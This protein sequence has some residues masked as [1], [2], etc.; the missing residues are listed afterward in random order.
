MRKNMILFPVI[1]SLFDGGAAA[2]GT[3]GG[4]APAAGAGTAGDTQGTAPGDAGRGKAGE[5]LE[6]KILYGKQPQGAKSDEVRQTDAGT[7]KDGG[8]DLSAE[9]REAINGKYKD[10][11]TA[12]M[13]RIIDR[14]FKEAKTTEAALNATKPLTDLLMQRYGIADGDMG[15]LMTAVE[16]DDP[17]L[18]R[19][20]EEN[21]MSVEQQRQM[22][23]YE[24]ENRQLRAAEA[25]RVNEDR[26][27]ET[28][29][30]WMREAEDLGKDYPGF[31][32]RAEIENPDFMR[33][34]RAGI[35]VRHAYEVTHRDEIMQAVQQRT[36]QSTEKRV[37]D[38]IRA[39]GRRPRENGTSSNQA[40]ITKTDPSKFTKEDHAR[41]RERVRAGERIVF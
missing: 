16:N 37:M 25:Q 27:R 40:F 13:Q 8:G 34:L 30:R 11:F 4:N 2:G 23:R 22:D 20:A 33:L 18:S 5:S 31:D 29:A 7:A 21:G 24:R 1:L 36:A 14:R 3:A 19:R 15:K 32:L 12:E 28:T 9:F 39:N 35:P 17:T 38:D 26:A 10:A 6:P 41:I